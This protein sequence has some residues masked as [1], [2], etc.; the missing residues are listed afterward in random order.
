VLKLLIGV[1]AGVLLWSNPDAKRITAQVLRATAD[2]LH[3]VVQDSKAKE[4]RMDN[5]LHPLPN[6]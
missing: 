2:Y 5:P 6:N 3:P 4:I 1:G